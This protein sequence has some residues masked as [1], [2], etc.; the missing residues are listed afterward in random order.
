[1]RLLDSYVTRSVLTTTLYAVF[2]LSIVL[3]LG[4]IFKEALDLLINRDVPVGYLLFFIACVLPFSFTFTIP[5]AFLTAVLL[6]FGRMSADN[7][8]IALRACGVSLARTC[9][10]VLLLGTLLSVFCLWISVQVAPAAE[11][12]MRRSLAAMAKSN[13]SSLFIAGEVIDA[14]QN[15]KIYVGGNDH[16]SLS[17]ITIVEENDNGGILATVRAR[18]GTIEAAPDGSALIMTLH[19]ALTEQREH[20]HE[21]D[22]TAITHG[23]SLQ[24]VSVR[25]PLDEL[26]RGGL[27]DRPLRTYNLSEL[28][29]LLRRPANDTSWPPRVAVL[30]E[31]S[32]RPS[33]ALASLA[34]AFLALPLGIV[35]QRK[36]TSAGFAISIAV[37]FGYYF[38]VELSHMLRGRADAY[39]YLI[40]W[41]PNALFV[42][43]GIWLLWRLDRR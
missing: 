37:A 21:N 11:L 20:G 3:I 17:D 25:V 43:V 15:R 38:F 26:V 33:L 24:E 30:T 7:E 18:T 23:V 42:S 27:L 22:L 1:M 4:N 2:V 34:F 16:G 12:A 13:P 10:P 36:E 41:I 29:A 9:I 6:N 35:A 39:P 14:F 31:L 5:W 19:N 40:L 28:F 32:K 8:T